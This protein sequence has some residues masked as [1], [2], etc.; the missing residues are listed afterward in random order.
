MNA[1]SFKGV[2]PASLTP[3]KRNGSIN[4]EMIPEMVEFH[5][6]NGVTGFYV[7]GNTGEGLVLSVEERKRT[8]SYTH[9]TLPTKA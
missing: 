3:F 1:E 4:Y 8:V 9:L 5:L 6:K 2:Y 7:C